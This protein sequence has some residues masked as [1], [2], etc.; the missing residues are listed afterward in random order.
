MKIEIQRTTHP[1]SKPV[2]PDLGF[3]RVFTDHML[4]MD[5]DKASGWGAPRIV[6][7][8][9]LS[10]DPS[11]TVFHYAQ[12]MFEGMKAFRGKDGK[13]R[14]FRAER[15]ARR[16][17]E[18]ARRLCMPSV[19]V[20]TMVQSLHALIAVDEEWVPSAPM[21]ALYIRPTMI[22]TDPVLGVRASSRYTYFVI[23]S[24]VGAYYASGFNP[25]KIWIEEKYVRAV[26]GG[27]GAV[28]ASANY[29]S[30]LLASEEA[31][32]RGY[33]Q[34]LW[35]DAK[36][37]R[38]IEEVGTMNLFVRINDE[39]VTAPLEGTILG[40]VTRDCVLTLLRS[41]GVKVTERRM[42]VEEL[43]GAHADGSLKE[44]FGSGTAAVIS[45][46]GELGRESGKL[47]VNDGRVGE[48]SQR[49]F[50][51]ITG[52]QYGTRPDTFGWLTDLDRTALDPG[53]ENPLHAVAAG[54]K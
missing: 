15:H 17:A 24:P 49:L 52:I 21:T 37:H 46:V 20:E 13:I 18:G 35:L 45:A 27:T 54:M 6:P 51:E 11:T 48:L 41:W 9:P 19:D 34:V 1:R 33:A 4:L 39:V 14:L 50:D 26:A 44:V 29:V 12:A 25:Q 7:Y 53:P 8:G 42:S 5:Y 16:M 2:L 31:K 10:L 30:S 3:G 40:G 36:E 32:A 28:K 22:G 23:L 43:V 47:V 38:Y